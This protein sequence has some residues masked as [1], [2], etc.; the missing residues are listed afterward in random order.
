MLINEYVNLDLLSFFLYNQISLIQ[1]KRCPRTGTTLI[2]KASPASL[3]IL[4]IILYWDVG[5]C[6]DS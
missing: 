6:V 5:I 3:A 1:A 4:L 2:F